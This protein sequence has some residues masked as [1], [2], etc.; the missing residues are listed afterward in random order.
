MPLSLAL[1]ALL[2]PPSGELDLQWR[3]PSDC[4]DAAAVARETEAALGRPLAPLSERPISARGAL[5]RRPGPEP[6]LLILEVRRGEALDRR[7]F[8]AARCDVLAQAAAVVLAAAIDPAIDVAQPAT[9]EPASPQAHSASAPAADA[10]TP[11]TAAPASSDT[12]PRP[13]PVTDDAL[14]PTPPEPPAE[15][16]VAVLLRVGPLLALGLVPGVAGGVTG[17]L[18]LVTP[19]LRVDLDGLWVAPRIGDPGVSQ[20]DLRIGVGVGAATLRLC[21]RPRLGPVEFPTCL[22]GQ[23][24]GLRAR[25]LGADIDQP[26]TV[27][28]PWAALLVGAGLRAAFAR[29]R[30]A[31]LLRADALVALARPRIG[32]AGLGAVYTAPPVALQPAVAL[33]V[34]LP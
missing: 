34:K 10:H 8:R 28:Q 6:Y 32:L 24:G 17:G 16:R 27:T 22:G 29:G 19:R 3:G 9:A 30:L 2:A 33:E 5:E 23:V 7:E 15:P 11:P 21:A 14:A 13:P 4:P 12:T 1:A 26:T 18:G 31:L 25:P 20:L